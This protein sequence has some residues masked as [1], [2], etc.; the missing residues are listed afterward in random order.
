MA[1]REVKD[2]LIRVKQEGA[3]KAEKKLIGL[4]KAQRKV[5]KMKKLQMKAQI[6]KEKSEYVRTRAAYERS[7]R[8]KKK[9]FKKHRN[10]SFNE[11][12]VEPLAIQKRQAPKFKA[13]N[14]MQINDDRRRQFKLPSFD[15]IK[16]AGINKVTPVFTRFKNGMVYATNAANSL[17][18]VLK[19]S[20]PQIAKKWADISRSASK[21]SY[22]F[23]RLFGEGMMVLGAFM[24]IRNIMR[25][26][27]AT[28]LAVGEKFSQVEQKVM[29]GDA[30]RERL[31]SEGGNKLV[32]SFNKAVKYR[33]DLTGESK[34]DA[35]VVLSKAA[36]TLTEFGAKYSEKTLKQL[37]DAAFGVAAIT[38]EEQTSVLEKIL[39]IAQEGKGE[40]K[41]KL[42]QLRLTKN[43]NEN[44]RR[45]AEGAYANPIASKVIRES[46][47]Q[48]SMMR[49]KNGVYDLFANV[50]AQH[51]KQIRSAF[52]RMA[53]NF[54]AVLSEDT[55]VQE[56]FERVLTNFTTALDETFAKDDIKRV[57]LGAAEWSAN[58]IDATKKL[59]KGIKWVINNPDK[60]MNALELFGKIWLGFRAFQ[61]SSAIV[62]GV[63]DTLR[64][65]RLIK[66][67]MLGFASGGGLSARA[68]G[69]AI[70]GITSF[71]IELKSL[72]MTSVGA[73]TMITGAVIALGY[74]I[75][76]LRDMDVKNKEDKKAIEESYDNI[77]GK[78]L[79]LQT[80]R[81]DLAKR[82]IINPDM[83]AGTMGTE[84]KEGNELY[85]YLSKQQM[86]FEDARS[87]AERDAILKGS[88]QKVNSMMESIMPNSS[89]EG[90]NK[91][92]L[93]E[94]M[95]KINEDKAF[96]KLKPK[97][98]ERDVLI[99]AILQQYEKEKEKS[100]FPETEEVA[101]NKSS[102]QKTI[103]VNGDVNLNTNGNSVNEEYI[104]QMA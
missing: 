91:A 28:I 50:F 14:I 81:D 42:G 96:E 20:A 39:K 5:E 62:S 49:M 6:K 45:I 27:G 55:E 23:R 65:L 8:F 60:V 1:D 95:D 58:I 11:R 32:Q 12:V 25:R 10:T 82:G 67:G 80:V 104:M 97:V 9:I 18:S 24:M 99:D 88:I 15:T 61:I 48:A 103:V 44:I 22:L 100:Y 84:S 70:S 69:G 54:T 85:K 3:E 66:N 74:G 41:L 83:V 59:A 51:P 53:D 26:I 56:A 33:A 86:S 17:G 34:A 7:S 2:I 40:E 75:K 37:S 47:V 64:L 93:Q 98:N 31:F 57:A 77:A 78:L 92:S 30:Y 73:T 102:N 71:G 94:A 36:T 13:P 4:S 90:V 72:A 68:I 43:I 87:Q 46:S 35:A 29:V 38:G 101:M 16:Q 21:V 52:K 79:V 76:K 89:A 63:L 19:K